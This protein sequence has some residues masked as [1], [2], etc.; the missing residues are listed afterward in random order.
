MNPINFN[1]WQVKAILEG[2][3]TQLIVPVPEWQLPLYQPIDK[4]SPRQ[5]W[6]ATGQRHSRWGYGCFGE[7]EQACLAELAEMGVCHKARRHK[8]YWVR[9]SF[10]FVVRRYG[11]GTGEFITYR[12][13]DENAVYCTEASGKSMPVKWK[14][15]M[16]MKQ[17]QARIII[18]PCRQKIHRLHDLT[19][20]ELAAEGIGYMLE[21]SRSPAGRAFAEAEHYQI[22]G[23]SMRHAPERYGDIAYF[24]SIGIDWEDNPLVWVIDFKVLTTNGKG[25]K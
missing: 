13:S 24:K 17:H 8:P 9:E 12:A 22:G 4:H 23:A 25:V 19:G 3:K 2:C 11:G 10:G 16:H 5:N 21:D 18:E 15:G 7:T 1:L 14:S 20:D 6:M